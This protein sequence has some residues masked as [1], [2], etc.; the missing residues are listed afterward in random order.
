MRPPA[1]PNSLQ[2]KS[3]SKASKKKLL[4]KQAHK[5]QKSSKFAFS[6][7]TP[8]EYPRVPTHALK[9]L[10]AT[11]K[12]PMEI[13]VPPKDVPLPKSPKAIVDVSRACSGKRLS[14]DSND[15]SST[16]SK[17][18]KWS[19]ASSPASSTN[20]LEGDSDFT[21]WFAASERTGNESN[22]KTNNNKI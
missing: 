10:P 17:A 18:A 4:K 20:V 21:A 2:L 19:P 11:P 15:E 9:T 16:L 8:P 1:S 14:E 12:H 22:N 13:D 3:L 7:P 5:L 6:D